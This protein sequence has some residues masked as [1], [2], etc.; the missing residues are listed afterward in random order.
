M[1]IPSFLTLCALAGAPVAFAQN[2]P[3]PEPKPEPYELKNKSSFTVKADTRVPFWPVGWSKEKVAKAPAAT[4]V[5]VA[6]KILIEPE[7]FTVTSVLLSHPP[8][9]TINGRSFGEGE[10]LPVQAGGQPLRVVVKAIRD[11]GVWLDQSGHQI[12]VPMKRESVPRPASD[13][14]AQPEEFKINIGEKE[15]K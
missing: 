8:L 7:H 3:K 10:F 9:A 1:K 14:K 4:P 13:P 15:K 5:P 2:E 12:F 6:K 11:G